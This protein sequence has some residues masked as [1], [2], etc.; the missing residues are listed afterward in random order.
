VFVGWEAGLLFVDAVIWHG[1]TAGNILRIGGGLS[2]S[3][4]SISFFIA[5][6]LTWKSS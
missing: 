1:S 2:L 3:S 4:V 5:A 6:I